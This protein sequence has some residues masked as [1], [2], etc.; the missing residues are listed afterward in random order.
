MVK[1]IPNKHSVADSQKKSS[2]KTFN[3]NGNEF[4][5][6]MVKGI[7][8]KRSVVYSKTSSSRK[9]VNTNGEVSVREIP[10]NNTKGVVLPEETSTRSVIEQLKKHDLADV[11]SLYVYSASADMWQRITQFGSSW[12]YRTVQTQM[13]TNRHV[14]MS[15]EDTINKYGNTIPNHIN[16]LS[17]YDSDND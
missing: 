3:T 7:L 16:S 17:I 9:K 10:S 13:Y 6:K 11:P 14:M 12:I 8:K 5:M 15:L 4:T 1:R 2:K